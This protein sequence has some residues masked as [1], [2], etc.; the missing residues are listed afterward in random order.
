MENRV[1]GSLLPPA[2]G[3]SPFRAA[4]ICE[5]I[6]FRLLDEKMLGTADTATERFLPAP[7]QSFT[8]WP[9]F[10]CRFTLARWC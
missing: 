6:S 3:F 7:N 5:S 9:N 1:G 10:S 8:I 2:L 4:L